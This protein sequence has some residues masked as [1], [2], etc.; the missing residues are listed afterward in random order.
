MA[1]EFGFLVF[2]RIQ[3][4]DLTAAYEVFASLPGANVHL[5]WKNLQ[6]VLSATGLQLTPTCRFAE[7]PRLDVLCVPGGAGVNVLL[8]D[9]EVLQFIRAQ[10]ATA[11][12]VT[13][14]CTGAL[15][16]GGSFLP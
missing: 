13:S 4:L 2:P 12:Y 6:P 15:L 8:R 1:M 7:C 5:V 3:Q 10:A 11:R 9:E 14:V 16:L